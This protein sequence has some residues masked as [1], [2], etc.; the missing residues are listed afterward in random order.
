MSDQQN[1]ARPA[2]KLVKSVGKH[3]ALYMIPGYPLYGAAKSFMETTTPG[4]AVIVDLAKKRPQKHTGKRVRTWNQ[5]MEAR[6]ADALPLREIERLNTRAK[7]IFMTLGFFDLCANAS[8]VIHVNWTGL[9]SGGLFLLICFMQMFKFE[10][11]LRQ[12]E[13]GPKN[14]DRFLMSAGE[15]LRG[16]GFIKHLLNPRLDWK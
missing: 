11:R 1:N 7:Q 9:L 12:M 3:V 10:L 2:L 16:K 4:A 13:I 5:A 14:P 15:F 8:C 6:P